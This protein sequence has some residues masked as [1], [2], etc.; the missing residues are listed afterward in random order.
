MDYKI[1]IP[2]P[3][4]EDWNTMAPAEK[5][6]F[7]SQ[8]GI[9]VLDFT[10]VPNEDII[11]FLNQNKGSKTCARLRPEQL[12]ETTVTIPRK[13]LFSQ[14]RFINIFLLALLISMGSTLFSCSK[15][16]QGFPLGE[17]STPEDMK[18]FDSVRRAHDSLTIELR[19]DSLKAKL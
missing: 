6:K 17:L 7:C 9:T 8:C 3:C 18:R 11:V 16:D 19:N 13:A 10:G 14:T 4:H 5:G 12:S 15:K 2:R 1:S